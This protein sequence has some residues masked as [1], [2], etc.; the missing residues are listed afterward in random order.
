MDFVHESNT[1]YVSIVCLLVATHCVN[2]DVGVDMVMNSFTAT[3]T[4][5]ILHVICC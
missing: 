4:N 2:S 1:N 3:H 5:D